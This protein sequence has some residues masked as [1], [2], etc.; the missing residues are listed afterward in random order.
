MTAGP[1]PSVTSTFVE[2]AEILVADFDLVDLLHLIA[3][4]AQEILGV[5]AVG[6]LL[7]DSHGGL[8]VIAASTEQAQVL[9]LSQLQNSEGPCLDCYRSGLAVS[10]PD[11]RTETAR[12]PLFAPE[13][14]AAGFAG[15]HALPMR[16]RD[17][18]IGGMNLFTIAPGDLDH[19]ILAV[20]QALTDV[21]AIALLHERTAGQ[22]KL[23]IE[24]LQTALNRR[25]AVEQ[26]KGV[27]AERTGVEVD[28]AFE[29]LR[30]Y[31][32]AQQRTL[33]DLA[34]TV[35]HGGLTPPRRDPDQDRRRGPDHA[36]TTDKNDKDEKER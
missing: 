12:W 13:A 10:C 25:L 33:A 16:L 2:L 11:L 4:R 7:A 30:A 36:T 22:H 21:A 6:L 15:V 18:L 29:M 3:A 5:D 34:D 8:N 27:I 17:E 1:N 26:A 14:L 28:E 35:I 24:G 32:H 23:L 20:G 9:E 19:D 31:A